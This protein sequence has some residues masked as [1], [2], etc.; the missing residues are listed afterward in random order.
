M[1]VEPREVALL[2]A[3]AVRDEDGYADYRAGMRPILA[4]HGGRFG[5]DVRIA[6]VLEGSLGTSMNRMFTIVFPSEDAQQRFFSDTD[7][8]SIRARW[9]DPSVETVVA[10][11]T[12]Q[13]RATDS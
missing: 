8:R 1:A 12:V 5:L 10:L 4:A 6:E 13:A 11:G 7:Y 3:L 9:F 2:F